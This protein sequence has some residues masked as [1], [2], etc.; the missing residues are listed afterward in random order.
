MFTI[1]DIKM[2]VS[3]FAPLIAGIVVSLSMLITKVLLKLS[4]QMARIGSSDMGDV[5]MSAWEV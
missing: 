3:F 1:A 4:V 5:G 2:Q